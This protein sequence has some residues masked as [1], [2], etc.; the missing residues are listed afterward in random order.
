MQQWH[1]IHCI[2]YPWM[3]EKVIFYV[4]SLGQT[5]FVSFPYKSAQ[6]LM[7]ATIK[8]CILVLSVR[9]RVLLIFYFY[10]LTY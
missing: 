2:L 4:V 8:A 9:C 5:H 6:S 7:T 1:L 10:L 3:L